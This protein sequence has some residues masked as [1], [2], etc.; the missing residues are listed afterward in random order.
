MIS[1]DMETTKQ[2]Q[3]DL[4][5][6]VAFIG[7]IMG[8]TQPTTFDQNFLEFCQNRRYDGFSYDEAWDAMRTLNHGGLVVHLNDK[9]IA[10]GKFSRL[11]NYQ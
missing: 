1:Y 5:L 9:Y 11:G 8:Q 7:Q 2:N 3:K 4:E 6:R 10:R